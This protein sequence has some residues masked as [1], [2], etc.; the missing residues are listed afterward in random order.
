MSRVKKATLKRLKILRCIT[1][2]SSK[3]LLI[4]VVNSYETWNCIIRIN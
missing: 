1:E 4:E 3:S 2:L